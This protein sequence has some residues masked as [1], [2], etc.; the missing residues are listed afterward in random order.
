MKFSMF[1]A[2][3]KACSLSRTSLLYRMPSSLST[4]FFNFFR[5][6]FL[7][8]SMRAIASFY[9]VF[10]CLRLSD[11]LII[12]PKILPLVNG[13]LHL[14]LPFFD[15]FLR[16]FCGLSQES[17]PAGPYPLQTL[18]SSPLQKASQELRSSENIAGRLSIIMYE[19]LGSGSESLQKSGFFHIPHTCPPALW[20]IIVRNGRK[21]YGQI[22][23]DI[24]G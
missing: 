20:Y 3:F 17:G 15:F 21:E 12:L 14:F 9:I 16:G 23:N 2:F 22:K 1:S 10:C 13:F 18:A 24:K 11:S 19:N 7:S 6:V 5:S 4:T 8:I